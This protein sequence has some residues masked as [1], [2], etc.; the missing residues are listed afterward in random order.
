MFAVWMNLLRF[1]LMKAVL[2]SVLTTKFS[3]LSLLES[4]NLLGFLCVLSLSLHH[5]V[6]GTQVLVF[7]PDVLW[8][9]F[10]AR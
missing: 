8:G 5:P 3:A 6:S 4:V 9:V 1:K 2:I 7:F 10:S